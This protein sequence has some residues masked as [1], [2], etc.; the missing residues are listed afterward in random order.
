MTKALRGRRSHA[1]G[2]ILVRLPSQR[3]ALG[4]TGAIRERERGVAV[5]VSRYRHGERPAHRFRGARGCR[6]RD[7]SARRTRPRAHGWR[8]PREAGQPRR[9][10]S[11]AA[12][13]SEAP[14]RRRSLRGACYLR[15]SGCGPLPR[16]PAT[17][18]HRCSSCG[19][20]D[21]VPCVSRSLLAALFSSTQ[22]A[23]ST[24]GMYFPTES[25]LIRPKL[26]WI[27]RRHAEEES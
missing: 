22:Y 13:Q 4:G 24:N 3:H 1:A 7:Q 8:L 9:R 10:G 12:R 15:C 20:T 6:D 17:N 21:P 5:R 14:A 16:W 18:Q 2:D 26:E 19:V 23:P 25:L 11:L 27:A